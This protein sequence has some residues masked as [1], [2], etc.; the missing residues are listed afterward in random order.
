MDDL[1]LGIDHLTPSEMNYFVARAK[2]PD[3][4]RAH[5]EGR[6]AGE[7]VPLKAT[8]ETLYCMAIDIEYAVEKKPV[9]MLHRPA[10]Q[11]YIRPRKPA[12]PRT[13]WARLFD[14]IPLWMALSVNLIIILTL[15]L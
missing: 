14:P 4:L 12:P 7:V 15:T 8:T 6:A 1:L 11:S 10:A 2:L 9:G 3:Q 13:V 5:A